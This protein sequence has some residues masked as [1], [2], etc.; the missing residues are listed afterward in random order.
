MATKKILHDTAHVRNIALVGHSGSGKTTL[1]ETLLARAGAIGSAGRIDKGSTV[2]DFLKQEK[3]HQHSLDIAVCHFDYGDIFVNILDTPGY[4]DFS[5]RSMSVLAG[6]ETAAV[7]VNAEAGVEM[8]AQR[9]M[10]FADSQKLC[11]MIIINR[12]DADGADPEAV[13]AQVRDTFGNECLPLNLPANGASTVADCFFNLSDETPD[14][15]S[16]DAAHT[17]MI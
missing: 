16:V 13:L 12:I 2:S 4:P 6:V 14:F 5:G 11:R 9:L 17:E 1:L 8:V 3:Q 15:S 10:D 7:V